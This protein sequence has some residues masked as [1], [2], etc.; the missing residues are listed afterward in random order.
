MFIKT[1]NVINDNKSVTLSYEHGIEK[2]KTLRERLIVLGSNIKITHVISCI[3]IK[4]KQ[5]NGCKILATLNNGT[6]I[7]LVNLYDLNEVVTAIENKSGID[8]FNYGDSTVF[9]DRTGI[10]IVTNSSKKGGYIGK[11]KNCLNIP[12]LLNLKSRLYIDEHRDWL[13]V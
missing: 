5:V 9:V 2:S 4:I 1:V 6:I 10:R 7:D 12:W 8:S 11:S 3:D 13:T